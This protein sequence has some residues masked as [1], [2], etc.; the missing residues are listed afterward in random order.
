MAK[1][2]TNI[3]IVKVALTST[4]LFATVSETDW[5]VDTVGEMYDD[6]VTDGN[7]AL[8]AILEPYE[9]KGLLWVQGERD[10]RFEN[11][12]NA[13][14]TNLTNLINSFRTDVVSA[15]F[16]I[17][18]IHDDLDPAIYLYQSTV[19]QAM[20]DITTVGGPDYISDTYLLDPS[21]YTLF[22]DNVHFTGQ[23]QI[24]LSNAA[25]LLL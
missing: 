12:A 22:N 21:A 1:W 3:Y 4:P 16:V 23:T 15:R 17:V 25:L 9:V 7:A 5:N 10:S 2:N 6:L 13:Y 8:A 24:D 19:R 11:Y 14:K 18:R 20:I